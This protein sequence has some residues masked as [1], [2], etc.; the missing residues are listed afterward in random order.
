[1]K[2]HS[3]MIRQNNFLMA[4][5]CLV[6]P[7]GYG[8]A[9][10]TEG[11]A[12]TITDGVNECTLE[13]SCM[14]TDSNSTLTLE[15]SDGASVTTILSEC[16]AQACNPVI[17]G[18]TYSLTQGSTPT[19]Y[20]LRYVLDPARCPTNS[21]SNA[22]MPSVACTASAGNAMQIYDLNPTISSVS[23]SAGAIGESG[24]N[25][26]VNWQSS[27]C[28]G[29]QGVVVTLE[30]GLGESEQSVVKTGSETVI[31]SEQTDLNY[32][33]VAAVNNPD[34]D[35]SEVVACTGVEVMDVNPEPGGVIHSV[36]VFEGTPPGET[37]RMKLSA[38]TGSRL[39]LAT[40]LVQ[41]N[42]K[43][44]GL[45]DDG[46]SL[47][48]ESGRPLY[49]EHTKLVSG[50]C[51]S[52][53]ERQQK[54]GI[55][56]GQPMNGNDRVGSDVI[57]T[58]RFDSNP[59]MTLPMDTADVY[60]QKVEGSDNQFDLEIVNRGLQIPGNVNCTR[61]NVNY[62]PGICVVHSG[63][64]KVLYT[65]G[66]PD[67]GDGLKALA[68]DGNPAPLETTLRARVSTSG[69]GSSAAQISII[70]GLAGMIISQIF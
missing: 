13:A 16:G 14:G 31:V 52:G 12:A 23:C 33:T 63:S 64:Q 54:D 39:S 62:A 41:S 59:F 60:I 9:T 55:G 35:A 50:I 18:A 10:L 30:N 26:T 34:G 5:F 43:F 15:T 49:T 66:A 37:T 53:T 38:P 61:F 47:Y 27:G 45:S 4:F 22:Y 8:Q 20:Q 29:E 67:Y 65:E 21:A 51:T 58:V 44:R 48:D 36:A 2:P 6:A 11:M 68:E 46:V 25:Y 70:L 28:L 3:F 17:D 7:L 24:R 69:A 40:M 32:V 56:N 1:M 19:T 42:S 57:G